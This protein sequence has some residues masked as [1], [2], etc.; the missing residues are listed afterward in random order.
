MAPM[1]TQRLLFLYAA[2]VLVG[3]VAVFKFGINPKPV[4][5]IRLSEFQNTEVVVTATLASLR[6]ELR[7]TPIL[8]FG[9]S[10]QDPRHLEILLKFLELNQ[11]PGSKYQGVVIE[12]SLLDVSP[13]ADQ[14]ATSILTQ[15]NAEVFS[16]LKNKDQFLLGIEKALQQKNRLLVIVPEITAASILPDGISIA[17]KQ[18]Y[19]V[20][21][22]TT[23]SL[24]NFP[25]DRQQE[26]ELS[27]PCRTG[28]E[29][30][31]QTSKVGCLILQK[32]RSLYRKKMKSG[33]LVGFMIQVGATDFVFPLTIEP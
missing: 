22:F 1:S 32:A 4:D 33:S 25:R 26:P 23:L 29:D 16:I 3:I 18:K 12:K 13:H 14:G 2:I 31:A 8:I 7:N 27:I 30:L 28:D 5:K 9:V 24:A 20:P 11:E 17:L 10:P 21:V 19:A 15:L 6:Q